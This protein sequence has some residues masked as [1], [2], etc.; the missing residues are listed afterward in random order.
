[1]TKW[2][3]DALHVGEI[4]D[5]P[6]TEILLRDDT[7]RRVVLPLVMFVLR[8]GDRT[9][10]VDTGG[11]AAEELGRPHGRYEYVPPEDG[12]VEALAR[13]GVRPEQ[14]DLVVNTHLH[15]DHCSNNE[16]FDNAAIVAQRAELAYAVAPVP[17][18]RGSY[19]IHPGV[20]PPFARSLD[21]VRAVDGLTEL[22]PGLGVVPLPG[23]SPGS[24]GVRVDTGDG[25]FVITG[26][27][28]D[29]FENWDGGPGEP[30]PSGRFTDL[31]AFYASLALLQ[32][33][34]WK[35]LPSHD[36]GV[37]EA[38]AFGY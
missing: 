3:I 11:P 24:Q 4:R 38:G 26:D 13:L 21:R 22:A 37:V 34:G 15:W 29:T 16:L 23:H 9:V 28:V 25:T 5:V 2:V 33:S 32:G 12:P 14:V 20:V 31:P 30:R 10:V 17:A 19:G 35:P 7:P 6:A 36:N 8:G 18:N 27:C 1:M